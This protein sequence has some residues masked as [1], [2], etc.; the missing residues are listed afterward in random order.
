MRVLPRAS[1]IKALASSS[2]TPST[3]ARA[4][5]LSAN[6]QVKALARAPSPQLWAAFASALVLTASP[7]F[8][9]APP[10]PSY[11]GVDPMSSKFIQGLVDKSAVDKERLDAERLENFYTRKYRIN[12]IIGAEV[13]KEPCDPR[14]PEYGFK[15]RPALPR[16]PQDRLSD[17]AFEEPKIGFGLVKSEADVD[18]A[19]EELIRRNVRAE[20]ADNVKSAIESGFN[21]VASDGTI[22]NAVIDVLEM[23]VTDELS[24]Q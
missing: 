23:S 19:A 6:A 12:S 2:E 8:A 1:P 11:S 10:T 7:S 22:E 21:I 4:L 16:L 17:E 18:S 13:L 24:V 20:S 9:R 14:D 15:C 3:S 5:P